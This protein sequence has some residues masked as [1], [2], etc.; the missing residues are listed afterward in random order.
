M[1]GN[2]RYNF[3][4]FTLETIDRVIY[5][6]ALFLSKQICL[7]ME[8]TKRMQYLHTTITTMWKYVRWKKW[9]FDK[10]MIFMAFIRRSGRR[11]SGYRISFASEKKNVLMCCLWYY[12]L[13]FSSFSFLCS[14]M[15][16]I[17][18][19]VLWI[20][21]LFNSVSCCFISLLYFCIFFLYFCF[22]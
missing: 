16:H 7:L 9:N 18:P 13:I 10:D 1:L 3:F 2:S 15:K 4:R 21:L 19:L 8:N 22:Y 14:K 6:L 17:L 12:L 5:G 11:S 20:V